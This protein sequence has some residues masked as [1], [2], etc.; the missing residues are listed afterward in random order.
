MG[1]SRGAPAKRNHRFDRRTIEAF[2]SRGI[3]VVA[4]GTRLQR[5]EGRLADLQVRVGDVL[6][7]YGQ[8]EAIARA[9][10]EVDCLPLRL[11]PACSSQEKVGRR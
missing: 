11:G 10:E 3:Q 9:L 4:I 6:L 5:I 1:R 2:L 7:L 8:P